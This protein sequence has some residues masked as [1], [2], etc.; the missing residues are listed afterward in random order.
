MMLKGSLRKWLEKGCPQDSYRY[1]DL[2]D[3][4][5]KCEKIDEALKLFK[6]TEEEGCDQNFNT[7][8]VLIRDC[9]I[10]IDVK[11]HWRCGTWGPLRV[12]HELQLLL[13]L[14]QLTRLSVKVVSACKILDEP[15][16]L[17]IHPKTL[18]SWPHQGLSV[19]WWDCWLGQ[20]NAKYST[21]YFNQ[22]LLE[23][24]NADLDTTFMHSKIGIGYDRMGSTKGWL[25][26]W[27]IFD[28]WVF[29]RIF[30]YVI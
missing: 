23:S 13:G 28:N 12:L 18:Q 21:Y 4:L 7:S 3:A 17:G 24:N 1:N 19:G 9:S 15:A 29:R 25:R 8:T 6:R 22:C 2:I 5:A 10:S 26:F 27:T 20:R 30:G 14:F 11:S 16:P